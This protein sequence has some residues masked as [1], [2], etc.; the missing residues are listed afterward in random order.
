MANKNIRK[1]KS[2]KVVL[3]YPNL[4]NIKLCSIICFSDAAFTD[5]KNGSSQERFIRFL[6]ESDKNYLPISWK[7]R[8][9][10]RV[11]RSK[12]AAKIL[13]IEEGLEEFI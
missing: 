11:V 1:L 7:S 6:Y 3:Q 2:E 13:A 5:L 10:Q 4:G 12:L 9:I 8:K